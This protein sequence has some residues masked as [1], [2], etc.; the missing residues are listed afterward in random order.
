MKVAVFSTKN[1]DRKYLELVNVKYHFQIEFFD[2]MLNERTAKMAEGCDVVCI[3]VNDDGSRT[4]LEKLAKV[5][6]KM[7]ALRCAG[8]NNVDIQAAK[9]LGIQ[10]VRVP[11]YSPE[12]VAEH[13]VGLMLTLNRRIHR[14][15]QRTREANFSLEGLTGFNMHNRTVGVI[16][17]GKIGIATM[18]ILKGFG[19]H[20][21]AYDPFKNPVA[22]ELGAEYV[23]LDELYARSHVITLHCPAT[24]ENYHLLN[25]AAF[26]KMKDGVMIINTSRGS[27]IDTPEAIEALKRRKIGALGMDVY[28]NE[29]DLFFE[30]KS[31]E[32]I[33]DDLF[34]RLSSCHNVLLTGHQAFLT[35]EALMNISDVTLYNI[36]CLQKG[37]RCKNQIE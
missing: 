16:G 23:T 11:A 28:E 17:T 37:G 35:E 26:D 7:I 24:P 10:V 18:R 2:F 32:V 31:N 13:T 5:G 29:R 4:V 33:L 20:I 34:R 27:L 12:A 9:E 6:V 21:L 30:D 15:Y 25:K 22:E 36:Y 1:Y 14:A 3:F 19:M 8:F